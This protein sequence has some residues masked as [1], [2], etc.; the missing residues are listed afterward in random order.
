MTYLKLTHVSVHFDYFYNGLKTSTMPNMAIS[1]ALTIV[2]NKMM[3]VNILYLIE[4]FYP[5]SLM[6]S[7]MKLNVRRKY[8]I[9]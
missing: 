4:L 7:K 8:V 3:P 2:Q 6:Y 1:T 9:T 5:G